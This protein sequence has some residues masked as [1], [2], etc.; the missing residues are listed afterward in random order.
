MGD[1]F[2]K[3]C[4]ISIGAAWLVMAIVL[5][6]WLLKKAPRWVHCLLWGLVGIRLLMPVPLTSLFSLMPAAHPLPEDF[7]LNPSPAVDSAIPLINQWL[8]PLL[9]THFAP[10]PGDS[11]NPVQVLFFIGGWVWL[12]G[13][14]VMLL[15]CLWSYLR[16]RRQVAPSLH[17]YGRVYACDHIAS[18]FILGVFRP[19]IYVPSALPEDAQMY[20]LRHEEAH[21]KRLDHWWKP[22]GYVL[23]AVYWFNPV[24][25]L[26]YILLCRDIEQACDERVVA[27]MDGADK[28][29]YAE[30]LLLCSVRSARIA[31]CPLAFGETGVKERICSV[32]SYRKPTVWIL[33]I[34]LIVCVA[35]A[36]LL[37]PASALRP[38]ISDAKLSAWIPQTLLNQ[39]K[40]DHTGDAYPCVDYE[41]LGV[42]RDG[43]RTTI[44]MRMMY[45]EYTPALT[46]Q[47]GWCT[48]AVLTVRSE[49]GQYIM[50]EYWT[51][52]DAPRYKSD[53]CARF[54][55]TLWY[56][57]MALD[58]YSKSAAQRLSEAAQTHF[59]ALPSL[60]EWNS[61]MAYAGYSSTSVFADALNAHLFAQSSVR[62]LPL[63][64]VEDTTSLTE[65][66]QRFPE[67]QFEQGFAE[68]PS[69]REVTAGCND[70]FFTKNALLI[71]YVPAGNP[72][73]RY[74]A[75]AISTSSPLTVNVKHLPVDGSSDTVMSGWWII[76]AVPRTYVD[77]AFALDAVLL[78]D[79][80]GDTVDS[81]KPSTV[82]NNRAVVTRV[83]E[84]GIVVRPDPYM[85]TNDRAYAS[86]EYF[87][88]AEKPADFAPGDVVA[89]IHTGE[90]RWSDDKNFPPI[91]KLLAI[92]KVS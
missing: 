78:H 29:G 21:L 49:N 28:K 24:L 40:N 56:N 79:Y 27:A 9:S 10:N 1:L 35:A 55:V 31:G 84:T 22:L 18:P 26:A 19:R 12:V 13:M 7:L 14:S 4:N 52:G 71:V 65:F 87:F 54:P 37:L 50:E 92:G 68:V 46:T 75:A 32:L 91:G 64:C 70:V 45:A 15:C 38:T 73:D 81:P 2:L 90:F 30:A 67:L 42:E 44:Y 69:F 51:P 33:S 60:A 89:I 16:L 57:A 25:W 74:A 66:I 5:L 72:D 61:T 88:A 6:R 82:K 86:S 63:Y 36:V 62:H 23:L 53:I 3:L 17:L 59:L 85:H 58:G 76:T 43:A 77:G 20:V 11:V 83:T 47:S 80:T 34:A 39:Y 8:N 41:V 48:P